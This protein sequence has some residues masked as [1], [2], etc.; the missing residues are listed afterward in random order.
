MLI[1]TDDPQPATG[2]PE[3]LIEEAREHHRLRVRRRATLLVAAALI[4]AFLGLGIDRLARG[5]GDTQ[6]QP[7]APT[8]SLVSRG[9]VTYEKVETIKIATGF[10]TQRRI[11]QIWSTTDAP[12]TYRELLETTDHPSLEVGAGPGHGLIGAEQIVY[13]Y[14]PSSDTIY[15][16]GAYPATPA[17]PVRTTISPASQFQRF[18]HGPD[19]HL[20]GTRTLD[21]HTVYVVK[22][23]QG[24]TEPVQATLYIDRH[25]YQPIMTVTTSPD[26][27]IIRRVLASKTLPATPQNLNLTTL[28]AAHP[29]ARTLPAPARIKALY[30]DAA[31]F[32]N[33]STTGISN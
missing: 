16:T 12:T 31:N 27:R 8:A 21:G 20:L 13:L 19:T 23:R 26:L 25:T 4:L 6:A 3:A 28:A 29:H 33:V 22:T 24:Q 30:G 18:V 10:P 14:E 17:P 2:D 7:P 15:L 32:L 5:G 11:V 9:A 1:A